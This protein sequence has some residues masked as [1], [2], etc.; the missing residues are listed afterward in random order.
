M[1]SNLSSRESVVT[2]W[3]DQGIMSQVQKNKLVFIE[4]QDFIE[5][6]VAL[7]NYIKV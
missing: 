3:V 1:Q 6:T 7:E 5:T 2:V 4:T